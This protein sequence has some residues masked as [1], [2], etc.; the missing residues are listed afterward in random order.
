MRVARPIGL[1]ETTPKGLQR[2]ARQRSVPA[3]VALRSRIVL[4][5]ADG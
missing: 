4:F 1:D 2:L 3:R 5:A